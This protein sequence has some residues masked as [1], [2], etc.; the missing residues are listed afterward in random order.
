[1]TNFEEFQAFNVPKLKKKFMFYL[2]FG[3]FS[4]K[5]L[6][7]FIETTPQ[8]CVLQKVQKER[9]VFPGPLSQKKRA[10]KKLNKLSRRFGMI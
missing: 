9:G 5:T 2:V 3:F 10:L 1:M 6:L 8:I 4:S 7:L